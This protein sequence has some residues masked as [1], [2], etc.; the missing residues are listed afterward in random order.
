[1]IL[2]LSQVLSAPDIEAL[3]REVAEAAFADGRATAGAAAAPVK[4]NE[5]A[6]GDAAQRVCGFVRSAL[7]RHP[8]FTAA[9]QPATFGA[10]L[11]SRYRPG[12]A[13]GWH[14]DNAVIAGVRSDL[15][16]TV[17][18]EQAEGGELELD[19]PSGHQTVRL[20]PGDAVLY[21]STSIHRVAAV[22]S[23]TR[24]AVVG[25][26]RS[27]VR[28]AEQREVLFDIA[29]VRT[30]LAQAGT[31]AAVQLQLQKAEANLIRL[32]AD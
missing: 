18:L 13:Y 3:H 26:L 23:G 6:T 16:F 29:G 32:W 25:W 20:E 10:V 17:L 9:A 15:S 7:E 30:A 14:V 8:V 2:I 4:H 11:L 19:L 5:Q 28:S 1:M 27:R 24:V 22:R 21:P 12:M 31:D